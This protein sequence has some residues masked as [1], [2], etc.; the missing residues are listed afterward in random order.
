VKRP[1]ARPDRAWNTGFFDAVFSTPQDPVIFLEDH[2]FHQPPSP[3]TDGVKNVLI[4]P[5]WHP[6]IRHRYEDPTRTLD[7]LK[8]P[9]HEAVVECE[10]DERFELLVLP[11]RDFDI[12]DF[13]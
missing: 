11:Q 6:T 10:S 9:N 1:R 5:V 3:S 13:H 4:A 12:G 8:P 2:F 7:N